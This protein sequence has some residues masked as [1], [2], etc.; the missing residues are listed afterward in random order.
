MKAD[1]TA[2]NVPVAAGISD[3]L[4]RHP[5]AAETQPQVP[6]TSAI[7]VEDSSS[8]YHMDGK[9]QLLINRYLGLSLMNAGDPL[10]AKVN[11]ELLKLA[12]DY[13]CLMHASLAVAL[14]YD[15]HVNSS[16]GHRRTVEECSHWSEATVLLNKRLLQPIKAKDKDP[17]WGTA[18][19]LTIITFS[20]PDACTPQDSWPLQ[21]S[22]S[23]DLYWLYMGE[24]KMSLWDILN[25]LR[26]DSIFR[27]MSA[28][29]ALMNTP[30]PHSG[31]DGIPSAIAAVC[32]LEDST[33]EESSSYFHAAH[34]VSRI[35]QLQDGEV[36]VAQVQFFMRSINGH[37][38]D[39]LGRK[40]PVAL[41]LL[42]LWYQKA[43]RSIWWIEARAKIECPS[44]CSY[45]HIYH[46]R[47][48][49]V[50]AFLSSRTDF[51]EVPNQPRFT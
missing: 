11:S 14:T 31:I 35:L 32:H 43:G 26:P 49:A 38:K 4:M 5:D 25:P 3:V 7:W 1:Q 39:L 48:T 21:C 22:R 47:N 10:M 15:R 41:L 50:M 33:T 20:S 27:V 23:S 2:K 18:A 45:L 28:T 34:A 19:A 46:S 8:S 12:F 37:F 9:C 42:Y 24:G 40:D 16:V 6:L 36:D 30:L 51:A 13:P 29:Y 17:I 44:I